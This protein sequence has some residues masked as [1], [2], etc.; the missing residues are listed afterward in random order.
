M[1]TPENTSLNGTISTDNIVVNYYYNKKSNITI[2]YYDI[3][4]KK[5]IA[6]ENVDNKVHYGDIY[7]VESKK[8]ETEKEEIF[9]NYNFE[10]NMLKKGI[11]ESDIK[12]ITGLTKEEIEE[13]KRK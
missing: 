11:K 13:L 10:K 3:E 6:K 2:K 5:E 12:E 9:K 7:N 4:T 1:I 8:I